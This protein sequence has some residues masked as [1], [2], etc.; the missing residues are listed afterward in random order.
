M[1]EQI[2]GDATQNDSAVSPMRTTLTF[3]PRDLIPTPIFCATPDG[4][5]VWMNASAEALTGRTPQ[6]LPGTSF[7]E[8]F[9]PDRRAQTARAFVRLRKKAGRDFYVEAPI[10]DSSGA[11]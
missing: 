11:A 10:T 4:R 3:D 2:P 5:M 6:D 7:A 9:P 8:F 1:D